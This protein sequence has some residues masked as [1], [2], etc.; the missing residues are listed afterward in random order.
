MSS[1]PIPASTPLRTGLLPEDAASLEGL[2]EAAESCFSEAGYAGTSLRQIADR[3][4]VSKSLL[5]YHFQSKEQLFLEVLVRIYNRLGARV[6][7]ALGSEG[8]PAERVL[9]AL[10][11][12]FEV[13]RDSP[14]IQVQAKVWASS[15][16]NEALREHA[17]RLREHLHQLL[18]RTMRAVLGGAAE[19]LPLSLEAAA[20]LLWA[21]MS[22]LGLQ[23]TTN[24]AARVEAAFDGLRR[25]AL[26]ALSAAPSR[27]GGEIGASAASSG[28]GGGDDAEL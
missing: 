24:D 11:T 18:V 19:A 8:A 17:E 12:L 22:G 23:T 6:R 28:A 25:L 10:D 16:S 27:G 9:Y 13:L 20:D 5:H 26:L 15:L 4:G 1:P 14:D 2:L 3:A 7:E 21:T